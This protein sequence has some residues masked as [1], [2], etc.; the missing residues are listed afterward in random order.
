[1][2]KL[3]DGVLLLLRLNLGILFLSTGWGKVHDLASVTNFF[4]ELHIPLPALNAVLVGYTELIGGALLIVGLAT[5][6]AAVPLV[7]S[8]IVAIL[9]AKLPDIGAPKAGGYEGEGYIVVRDP[10]TQ[11][12]QKAL[13]TIIETVQ[14]TYA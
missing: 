8:M 14:V 11:K 7:I 5:R 6:L 10:S 1:M 2:D 9:T 3:K 4:T 12:M 13:K